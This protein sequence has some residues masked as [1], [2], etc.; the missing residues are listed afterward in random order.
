MKAARQLAKEAKDECEHRLRDV[1]KPSAPAYFDYSILD[2]TI[3]CRSFE[4]IW[5][6]AQEASNSIIQRYELWFA[7]PDDDD[8]ELERIEIVEP[9]GRTQFSFVIDERN[10]AEL[11][12]WDQRDLRVVLTAANSAGISNQMGVSIPLYG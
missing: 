11:P 1:V 5:P 12:V 3:G 10:F 9:C 4:L 8:D 2:Y 6:A 7:L